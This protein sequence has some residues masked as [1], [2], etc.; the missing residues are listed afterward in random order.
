[1]TPTKVTAATAR[2]SVNDL[3]ASSLAIACYLNR[4]QIRRQGED[5]L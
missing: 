1:M 3:C 2:A 5:M 4:L